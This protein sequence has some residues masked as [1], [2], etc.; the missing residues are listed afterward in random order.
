MFSEK[1]F[2]LHGNSFHMQPYPL[3]GAMETCL[4]CGYAHCS[5]VCSFPQPSVYHRI[6]LLWTEIQ[7]CHW[8]S[9]G[10]NSCIEQS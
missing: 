10:L 1:V 5:P 6:L 8:T 4:I 9:G 7:T 3:V 2:R